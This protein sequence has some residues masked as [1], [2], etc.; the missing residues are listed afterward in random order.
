MVKGKSWAEAEDKCLCHAW[1][2]ASEDLITG[3]GQ[4][5]DSFGMQL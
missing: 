2:H 4:K 3:I 1:L 5:K